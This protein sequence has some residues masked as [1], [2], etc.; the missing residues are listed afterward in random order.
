MTRNRPASCHLRPVA[1]LTGMAAAAPAGAQDALSVL[2]P[3][4]LPGWVLAA[5]AICGTVLAVGL[6]VWRRGV[7]KSY[8][9]E[10]TDLTERLADRER[11]EQT[12]VR[13]RE[14]LEAELADI[15]QQRNRAA[16]ELAEIRKTVDA[17]L[18]ALR[19]ERDEAVRELDG[20]RR[21]L[22]LATA[23]YE[24]LARVD[25]LT[26]LANKARFD[27]AL[28][29]EIKR[30][31]RERKPLSM[32]IC[33]VDGLEQYRATVGA[34]RA[35]A[36]QKKIA[37]TIEGTFR[38]AGDLAARLD[39]DRIGVILPATD[40]EAAARFAERLMKS[41]W[42][43]CIPYGGSDIADRLTVSIGVSTAVPDRLHKPGDIVTA[44]ERSLFTATENGRNRVGPDCVV[45]R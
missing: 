10:R 40:E 13:M 45:S 20:A 33:E 14:T 11:S 12:Q 24:S 16:R 5:G 27:E 36:A 30:M 25:S 2:G 15:R 6:T 37:A 8:V 29:D 35:E 21:A 42:D 7:H 43:L 18:A 4:T 17:K 9:A 22:D 3:V 34:G 1:A 39:D 28:D 23:R 38:R 19:D 44:A 32:L 26:G 31:V 41:V